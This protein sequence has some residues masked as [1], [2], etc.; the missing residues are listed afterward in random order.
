M[1]FN[2]N[3]DGLFSKAVKAGKRTYFFDVRGMRGDDMYLTITESKRKFSGNENEKPFYEKHK[4][5]LYR[6]DFDKFMDG[7]E[8]A[9]THIHENAPPLQPRQP[10]N[11]QGDHA[12][13]ENPDASLNFDDLK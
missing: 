12:Q 13:G 1:D 4:I 7:L 8:A 11:N 3:R 10:R 9:F 6:E 2:E 5:F